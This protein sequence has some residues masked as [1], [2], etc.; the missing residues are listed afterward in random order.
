MA[1]TA[2]TAQVPGAGKFPPYVLDSTGSAGQVVGPAA[3]RKIVELAMANSGYYLVRV[4]A[5][6]GIGTATDQDQLNMRFFVAATAITSLMGLSVAAG[7]GS[8]AW[9]E[10]CVSVVGGDSLSVRAGSAGTA[11]ARYVAQ[12]IAT[13]FYVGAQ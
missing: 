12:I 9:M 6:L 13:P 3:D 1:Y 5:G 11:T 10:F 8:P 7:G 2:R 4:A